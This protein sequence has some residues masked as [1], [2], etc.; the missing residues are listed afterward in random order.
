MYPFSARAQG[1]LH[2][3]QSGGEVFKVADPEGHGEC[4]KPAVFEGQGLSVSQHQ[5]HPSVLASLAHLGAA[6]VEH[7]GGNVHA[8]HLEFRRHSRR[9]DGKIGRA[10]GDVEHFARAF[11]QQHADRLLAPKLVD[12]QAEEVVQEIIAVRDVVEHLRD[13][14]LLG[15]AAS[16][17]GD[18]GSHGVQGRHQPTIVWPSGYL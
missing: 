13:L 7:A 12:A 15:V 10:C 3:A 16:V 5:L 6:D 11:G 8:D 4:I 2:L 18:R 17:R 9:F 1:A 14:R